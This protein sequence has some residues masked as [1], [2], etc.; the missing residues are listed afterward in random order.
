[1]RVPIKNKPIQQPT[2]PNQQPFWQRQPASLKLP[3]LLLLGLTVAALILGIY[4]YFTGE[5]TFIAWVRVPHLQPVDAFIDQF[6]QAG[7]TFSIK[8]NG[9][10]LTEHF[11]AGLPTINL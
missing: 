5:S 3:Y 7:K 9:Y 11:D 4:Y 6:T 1:M 8:A 10:L 2:T